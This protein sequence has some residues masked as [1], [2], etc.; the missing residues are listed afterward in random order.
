MTSAGPETGHAMTVEQALAWISELFEEAPGRIAATTARADI[1]AWDSLGQLIL[2][3][4]LDQRF[5]IRL[6]PADLGSLVAVE[7][8]LDILARH[9]R[10]IRP[11]ES[12]D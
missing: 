12:R 4:A 3:S 5:G 8:I 6:T 9:G 2:M 1:P 10:L 11:A 7:Q